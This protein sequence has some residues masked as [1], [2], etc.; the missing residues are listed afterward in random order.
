MRNFVEIVEQI[1][2][3]RTK[4]VF[5][6]RLISLTIPDSYDSVPINDVAAWRSGDSTNFRNN[7]SLFN[8]WR[9]LDYFAWIAIGNGLERITQCWQIRYLYVFI[10]FSG[11]TILP[12]RGCMVLRDPSSIISTRGTSFGLFPN[13]VRIPT[14]LDR[15][16]RI[17]DKTRHTGVPYPVSWPKHWSLRG[18]L[19]FLAPPNRI[20]AQLTSQ[21]GDAVTPQ[22]VARR[23]RF[24]PRRRHSRSTAHWYRGG[25]TATPIEA[26]TRWAVKGVLTPAGDLY[27]SL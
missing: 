25:A 27:Q 16:G 23:R 1:F 11:R 12:P 7:V 6:T 4:S 19:V 13:I 22:T 17:M 3:P 9:H 2:I 20:H 26:Q 14:Q 10:H 18:N 21:P 15:T 24:R 8:R 5:R